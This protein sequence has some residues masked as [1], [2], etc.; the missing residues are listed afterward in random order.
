MFFLSCNVYR[1]KQLKNETKFNFVEKCHVYG[2]YQQPCGSIGDIEPFATILAQLKTVL[3][4]TL[5]PGKHASDNKN[6][7][8][9]LKKLPGYIAFG[10]S[11]RPSHFFLC[12]L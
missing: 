7:A 4:D 11:V 8:P 10:L 2:S 5:S 1:R 6:Y 12:L 3:L 9:T